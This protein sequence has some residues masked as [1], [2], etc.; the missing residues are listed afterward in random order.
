MK[1]QESSE[2]KGSATKRALSHP[3]TRLFLDSRTRRYFRDS[4]KEI[5]DGYDDDD[6]EK[7]ILEFGDLT[8]ILCKDKPVRPKWK[9]RWERYFPLKD[10]KTMMEVYKSKQHLNAELKRLQRRHPGIVVKVEGGYELSSRLR[11]SAQKERVLRGIG[12][13][14]HALTVGETVLFGLD[15][16]AFDDEDSEYF[17]MFVRRHLSTVSR[18][19]ERVKSLWLNIKL[20]E[21]LQEVG[22]VYE[23]IT[24]R[25]KGYFVGYAHNHLEWFLRAMDVDPKDYEAHFSKLR[26][27]ASGGD[28]KYWNK[29][30]GY[31]KGVKEVMM[32]HRSEFISY[33]RREIRESMP[34]EK[35]FKMVSKAIR[36]LVE[37][38]IVSKEDAKWLRTQQRMSR[39][40]SEKM[41]DILTS[42]TLD[43]APIL[44]I[45]T[46]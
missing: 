43:E 11:S 14:S 31:M 5:E 9:A 18:V 40:Y 12:G 16:Y 41:R 28:P 39:R 7:E 36:N 25:N 29:A 37:D 35:H 46:S 23:G 8:Y 1:N 13:M 30:E 45:D 6:D 3:I 24:E 32:Q 17:D 21:F 15:S 4:R 44:V 10:E 2:S 34:D 19:K 27:L 26:D 42:R 22:K 20:K 38:Q 33:V